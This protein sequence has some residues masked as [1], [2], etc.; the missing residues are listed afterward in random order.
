MDARSEADAP[1]G[2]N[3]DRRKR[4]TPG[5]AGVRSA[6]GAGGGGAD[7]GRLVRDGQL[8]ESAG[9]C[10]LP[11]C[12]GRP[13]SDGTCSTVE[14]PRALGQSLLVRLIENVV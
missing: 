10:D 5:F 3:E 2:R 8:S 13:D 6:G 9:A 7:G 11:V 4:A 1:R 12:L 14:Q